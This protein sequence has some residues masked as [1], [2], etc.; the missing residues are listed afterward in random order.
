MEGSAA[1]SQSQS[2]NNEEHDVFLDPVREMID[3]SQMTVEPI[4]VAAMAALAADKN[5]N[6]RTTGTIART[7][8]SERPKKSRGKVSMAHKD[9]LGDKDLFV[10]SNHADG[11]TGPDNPI[12]EGKIVK[13][14]NEK[15]NGSCCKVDWLINLPN[16][17]DPGCL[18]HWHHKDLMT[19]RLREAI[20]AC[21]NLLGGQPNKQ[22]GKRAPGT[23]KQAAVA[24]TPPD[25]GR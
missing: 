16:T 22:K 18:R 17:V 23:G 2:G 19:T 7:T 10:D 1:V 24:A 11:H 13:C 15:T 8:P 3:F 14:P 12:V 6:E 9:L 5:V 4:S 21:E 25:E 20:A